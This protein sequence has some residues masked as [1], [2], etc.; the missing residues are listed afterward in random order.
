VQRLSEPVAVEKEPQNNLHFPAEERVKQMFK[1]LGRSR[2]MFIL[3]ILP[4]KDSEIY[5]S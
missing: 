2:P 5:G 1:L 3:A 4:D